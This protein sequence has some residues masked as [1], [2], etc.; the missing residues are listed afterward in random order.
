MNKIE[1]F[2]KGLNKKEKEAILLLMLQIQKDYKKV[3]GLIKLTDYQDL[4]R[5]R[6]GQY[7]IIFKGY[8]SGRQH[9]RIHQ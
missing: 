8:F 4:F 2:L 3:P 7:R 5:V 6:I 1:K 9:E